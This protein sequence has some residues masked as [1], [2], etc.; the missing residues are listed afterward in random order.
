M[1]WFY[2]D[3]GKQVG[4]IEDA[5]LDDLV[6]SGVVRDDTLVWREGM[7]NWQPLSVARPRP[8]PPVAASIPPPAA[9]IEPTGFCSNCGRPLLP[10]QTA[11]VGNAVVCSTCA[12][13]LGHAPSAYTPHPTGFPGQ[14]AVWANRAIGYIIDSL[15]VVVAMAAIYAVGIPVFTSIAGLGGLAGS[16]GLNGLGA[17]GSSIGM[18]GCC[19]ML[20]LG[21]V[22]T[23]LVGL[24]N[25]VHLV[26]QR[27]YSVGQGVMKIKIVDGNGNLLTFQ[28]ALIRLLAQAGLSFIPFLGAVDLLWPLWDAQRQTLHDK[29]VGSFAINDP[30]RQ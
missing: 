12:P 21:P 6:R 27:G 28:T 19:C 5:A 30:A 4:P 25:K 22:A 26:S 14:P 9:P 7:P 11:Q 18:F 29:A 3:G 1:A 13:A 2:A 10:G 24:Y 8:T 23:I 20:A 16:Q 15:F 17:V